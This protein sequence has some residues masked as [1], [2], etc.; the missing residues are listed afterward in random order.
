MRACGL[1]LTD[2]ALVVLRGMLRLLLLGET[3]EEF[4][5]LRDLCVESLPDEAR[6]VRPVAAGPTP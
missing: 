6:P 5:A 3:D 1:A 2:Q 4:Q